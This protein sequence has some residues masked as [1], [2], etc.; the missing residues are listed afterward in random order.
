MDSTAIFSK[1]EN[2]SFL[3]PGH[4]SKGMYLPHINVIMLFSSI[5]TIPTFVRI[6]PGSI[7]DVSAMSKTINM[8]GVE[9]CVIVADKGFFSSDGIKKLKNKHLSYIIPLRRNSSLIPDTDN[10]TGFFRY[11]GKPVKYWKR[12]NDVCMLED[13]VLKSEEEQE[14]V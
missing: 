9:K 3:E 10:F 4:N 11:D 2:M 5:R 14:T 1:S 12:D 7:R 8:A 6:L 13:P